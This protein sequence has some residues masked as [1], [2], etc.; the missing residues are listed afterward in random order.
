M[1]T[2]FKDYLLQIKKTED[3]VRKEW[4]KEAERRVQFE[5][6]LALIAEKEKLDP[7]ND[8]VA[9]ALKHYREH[10]HEVPKENLQ[11][12]VRHQTRNNK[13]FSFLESLK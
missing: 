12:F 4:H 2:T 7:T 9:E 8:E 11:G 5:L 1:G 6:L 3:D 13:V 10:H